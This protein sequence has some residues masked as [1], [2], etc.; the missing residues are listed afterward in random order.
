MLNTDEQI[1][2]LVIQKIATIREAIYIVI[3]LIRDE[4]QNAAILQLDEAAD[5]LWFVRDGK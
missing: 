3:D 4:S 2:Q 1:D 5:F